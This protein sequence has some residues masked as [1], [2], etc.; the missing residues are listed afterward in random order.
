MPR[1]YDPRQFIDDVAARH[2]G[3]GFESI[4]IR[5]ML[6]LTPAQHPDPIQ[7]SVR[8]DVIGVIQGLLS[9]CPNN[10]EGRRWFAMQPIP[11]ETEEGERAFNEFWTADKWQEEAARIRAAGG[12]P[13]PILWVIL[14][15]DKASYDRMNRSTGHPLTVCIGE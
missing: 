4:D 9:R 8:T 3:P 6:G 13:H 5:P 2:M 12:A 14:W 10:T 11:A 7:V 15:S 1:T